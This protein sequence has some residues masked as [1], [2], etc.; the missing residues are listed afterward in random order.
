MFK[1]K[2]LRRWC[3][4][5]ISCCLGSGLASQNA[6]HSSAMSFGILT[7]SAE[8]LE[9]QLPSVV[10]LCDR[11][12]LLCPPQRVFDA[13]TSDT[14]IKEI[15]SVD[16][17]LQVSKLEYNIPPEDARC[18]LVVAKGRSHVLWKAGLTAAVPMRPPKKPSM[19]DGLPT[20]Q[21]EDEVQRR[22]LRPPP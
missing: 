20:C 8:Q 1:L 4:F 12:S 19:L 6:R 11:P 17:H 16:G 2:A 21:P 3:Q 10:R 5:D 14:I 9:L 7:T 15:T 13:V 18:S 22:H